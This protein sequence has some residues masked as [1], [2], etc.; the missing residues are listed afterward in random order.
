MNLIVNTVSSIFR[1]LQINLRISSQIPVN[2]TQFSIKLH[3][4]FKQHFSLKFC[5]KIF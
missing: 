5:K 1:N 2:S 4:L 3:I